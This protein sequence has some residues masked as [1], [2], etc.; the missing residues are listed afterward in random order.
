MGLRR[1]KKV[2]LVFG[3]D[4]SEFME[5]LIKAW[6]EENWRKDS[7]RLVLES[8]NYRMEVYG[9]DTVPEKALWFLQKYEEA[10]DGILIL[11]IE[12][13]DKELIEETL[14]FLSFASVEPK[15]GEVFGQYSVIS[16][17]AI[18]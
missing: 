6:E 13:K 15:K 12:D 8:E 4:I 7:N 10:E 5:E 14:G 11:D 18:Y 2:K 1:M 16:G 17:F 3:S 9:Y